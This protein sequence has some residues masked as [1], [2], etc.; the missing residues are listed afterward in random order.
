YCFRLEPG[1]CLFVQNFRMLHGR[2]AFKPGSGSRHLE[3]AYMDWS[4]FAGKRDFHK[5][6]HLYLES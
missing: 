3:I 5:I 1:D 4:Y 6:K 2:K